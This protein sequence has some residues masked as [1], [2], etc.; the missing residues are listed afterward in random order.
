[1]QCPVGT[2]PRE[3]DRLKPSK[4]IK[5]KKQMRCSDYT[6]LRKQF[7]LNLPYLQ[8]VTPQQIHLSEIYN[9]NIVEC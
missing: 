1:M 3:V 2:D 4:S 8:K 9:P 6:T 5:R 7:T